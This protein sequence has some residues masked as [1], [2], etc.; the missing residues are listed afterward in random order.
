M[1]STIRCFQSSCGDA[2]V[3]PIGYY[4]GRIC[5]VFW[6]TE[7]MQVTVYKNWE[8]FTEEILGIFLLFKTTLLR[9]NLYASTLSF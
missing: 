8:C 2:Q 1:I 6:G 9:Y 4:N 5:E 3:P 7:Y